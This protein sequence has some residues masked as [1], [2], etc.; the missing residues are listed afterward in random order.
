MVIIPVNSVC[1]RKASKLSTSSMRSK[2]RTLASA[3]KAIPSSR[4]LKRSGARDRCSCSQ[5]ASAY[6][7]IR[8]HSSAF[9]SAFKTMHTLAC[10]LF[11]SATSTATAELCPSAG[12]ACCLGSFR[13][14]LALAA[15]A[16]AFNARRQ[17]TSAH[18]ST[19]QH[20]SAYVSIRQ[21]TSAHAIQHSS[22]YGC[23]RSK[24]DTCP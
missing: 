2:S 10:S 20:T 5:H 19:R 14:M 16:T 11:R 17:H 1:T 7:S 4:P 22:A 8:Q 18:V 12:D 15:S 9:V 13:L 3:F 6:V 21:H 24:P 23:L